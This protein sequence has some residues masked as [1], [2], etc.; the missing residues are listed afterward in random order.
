MDFYKLHE[1]DAQEL[2]KEL[3]DY[4]NKAGISLWKAA[5]GINIDKRSLDTFFLK[6]EKVSYRTVSLIFNWIRRQ[7]AIE[8]GHESR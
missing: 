6:P 3:L 4:I 7:K 1:V 2:R 8:Q 5:E